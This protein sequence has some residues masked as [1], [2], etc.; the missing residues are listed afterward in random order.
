MTAHAAM[1]ETLS[2]GFA[3][4]V[5][6][7]QA[8]FRR[9]MSA[10]ASPGKVVELTAKTAPPPPLSRAAG[11]LALTLFDH[12][13]PVWLDRD[14]AA[15]QAVSDWLRFHTGAPI[16]QVPDEAAFAL[17]SDPARMPALSAFGQGTA[18]YP[19]RS[20]TLI[21]AV[22]TLKDQNLITLRG[23]GIATTATLAPGPLPVGFAD[24]LR[25]NHA[26]FPRGVDLVFVCG[27]TLSALPRSTRTEGA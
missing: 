11:A 17:V 13:T 15:A 8:V 1:T 16:T 22:E 26:Q 19:D 27:D 7:S 9:V 12:E 4:P 23:P 10:M 21:V 2:G 24:Q 18:D 3:H 25:A 5:F 6:D 20:T 14:L